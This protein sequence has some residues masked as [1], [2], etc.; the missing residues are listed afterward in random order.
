PDLSDFAAARGAYLRA[1][2]EAM[3]RHRLDA[4]VFPQ[5][6]QELPSIFSDQKHEATTVSEMN[7]AGI[8]GVTVPA[9]RYGSGAPFSLLFLGRMWSEASLMGYAYDY[10]QATHH[11]IVPDLREEPYRA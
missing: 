4:L 10:E 8:P 11:R 7:I 9:G 6:S 1:I 2:D 3:T 5:M